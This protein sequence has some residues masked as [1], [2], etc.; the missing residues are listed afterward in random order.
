ML[1]NLYNPLLPLIRY[2]VSDELTVLDGVCGCGSH[3]TRIADPQGRAD[4]VFHFGDNIVVHPHVLR[5][6]LSLPGITEY[7]VRQT[8]RGVH[9]RL[10][11]A[12][13]DTSA[14]EREIGRK[15]AS[16]G[17]PQ[18]TATVELVPAIDRLPSGK[19]QRFVPRPGAPT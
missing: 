1:T 10:V 13:I 8:N 5:S 17:L 18:P 7:Q 12:D 6:G 3:M 9:V 2:E 14:L 15:L 11:A 16:L 19:L 4:D